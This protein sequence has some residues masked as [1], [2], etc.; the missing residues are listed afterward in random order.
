[1]DIVESFLRE[2]FDEELRLAK[3]YQ[4]IGTLDECRTAMEKAKP[5][6]PAE[7][8]DKY[9][10]CPNCGRHVFYNEFFNSDVL[11]CE[12]CGQALKWSD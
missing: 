8:K 1:M 6:K 10:I 4:K 12:I 11:Y 5:K 7:D 9:Y 2:K 3:E